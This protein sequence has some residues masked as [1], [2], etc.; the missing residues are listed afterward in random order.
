MMKNFIK[1][2]KN[3][4]YLFSYFWKYGKVLFIVSSLGLLYAPVQ[5]YI[6][7]ESIKFTVDSI[8][9]GTPF[10]VI[11]ERLIIYFAVFMGIACVKNHVRN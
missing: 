6:T 2:F 3:L 7:I 5:T 9:I 1:S 8:T 10:S 4:F 11:A